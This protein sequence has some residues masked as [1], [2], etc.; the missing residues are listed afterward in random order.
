MSKISITIDVSKI[1]K[2]KITER[3]YVNKENETITLK[4]L[5]LDVVELKVP[6]VIKDTPEYQIMKTHFVSEIQTKEEKE[7]KVNS[8]IIG[9]GITFVSKGN[10]DTKITKKETSSEVSVEDLPW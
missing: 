2:D 10:G 8:K 7:N 6:K 4:E 3:S 9:E 5:K 1:S